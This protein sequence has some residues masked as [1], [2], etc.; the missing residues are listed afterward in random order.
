MGSIWLL[1]LKQA[2]KR[3]QLKLMKNRGEGT[4]YIIIRRKCEIQ[5]NVQSN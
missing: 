4:P 1:E 2:P 3:H 5:I